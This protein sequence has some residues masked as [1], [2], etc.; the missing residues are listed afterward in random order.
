MAFTHPFRQ[1]GF[2]YRQTQYRG[3]GGTATKDRLSTCL[4]HVSKVAA[5]GIS[6]PSS[7]RSGSGPPDARPV[8]KQFRQPRHRF[9]S[10]SSATVQGLRA[11]VGP[12]PLIQ[13]APAASRWHRGTQVD[14]RDRAPGSFSDASSNRFTTDGR[15]DAFFFFSFRTRRNNCPP[16]RGAAS[17]R[18]PTT[19]ARLPGICFLLDRAQAARRRSHIARSVF[20]GRGFFRQGLLPRRV[21]AGQQSRPP[22]FGLTQCVRLH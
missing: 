22:R 5:A 2:A 3:A 7:F 10:L 1:S 4:R 21:I 8:G 18:R 11:F 15:F 6:M 14:P 12:P 17:A 16:R 20:T 19:A 9:S 13:Q